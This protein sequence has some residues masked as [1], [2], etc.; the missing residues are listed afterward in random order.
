M[1]SRSSSIHIWQLRSS[2]QITISV[3]L[4]FL[5]AWA[6]GNGAL[7]Q[8][9]ITDQQKAIEIHGEKIPEGP[10]CRYL[11]LA[12]LP[13]KSSSGLVTAKLGIN[14]DAVITVVDTGTLRTMLS[15]QEADKLGLAL[16]H[17]KITTSDVNGGEAAIYAAFV[18]DIALD[19]YFWHGLKLEVVSQ[20]TGSYNALAGADILLNGVKRDIEFSLRTN[21][22]KVFVPF[23]CDN[24][25]LAYWDENASET[26]LANLSSH[27]PRLVVTVEINGKKMIAMIDS[28]SPTSIINLD[29]AA[30]IGITPRSPGVSEIPNS[31]NTGKQHGKAWLAS[32]ES[33]VIGSE[34]IKSP[35]IA[36][37]DLWGAVPA[38]SMSWPQSALR[39]QSLIPLMPFRTPSGDN[40]GVVPNTPSTAGLSKTP[41][42][43]SA[44]MF[45]E[46][47]DLL[48]GADFLKSHRVLLAISQG[49]L[50]YS[51]LGGQV[52]GNDD[53]PRVADNTESK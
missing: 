5:S 47:P 19:H 4:L 27:D 10:H 7:A 12:T 30:K 22:M 42:F 11:N 21:E 49:R 33:F 8:A 18:N 52:F 23:G 36:I 9:P 24:A 38:E 17:T 34:T 40:K 20:L 48:L 35:K 26:P 39:M 16:S 37:G 31:E 3:C 15:R 28:G 53:E 6:P 2:V 32:F 45:G 13:V 14:G 29:A 51:Y 1:K 41:S 44:G 25:F 43:H 46:H 50:Y